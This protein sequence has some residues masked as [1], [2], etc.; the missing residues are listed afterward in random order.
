MQWQEVIDNP[1][2]KNLPFKIEL[3][4][5]GKIEM[6]PASNRHAFLQ[7][8]MAQIIRAAIG[9]G[10]TLTEAS[11]QT[12]NGVRVPDVVWASEDFLS[13]HGWET[14]F[15]SAPEL[16]VE[17]VSPSNSRGEMLEKIRLYLEAGAAEVWLLNEAGHLEIENG[18]GV[19]ADSLLAPGIG[20]LLAELTQK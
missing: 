9:R 5:W 13:R 6:S 11:I 3:N 14:P 2:L 12:G 10:E 4:K 17:I 15:S 16:C 7:A 1:Y 18:E 20:Q 8:R 19:C